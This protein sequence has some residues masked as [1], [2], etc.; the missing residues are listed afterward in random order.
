MA[1]LSILVA[2]VAIMNWLAVTDSKKR[3]VEAIGEELQIVL[4]SSIE[5][6]NIWVSQKEAF[7]RQLG[8]D[9]ELVKI[10]KKLL[11]VNRER[12]AL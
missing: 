2:A 12:D 11:S 9:P 3:A 7:L 5:R 4:D 8:R 6:L 10:T 1:G